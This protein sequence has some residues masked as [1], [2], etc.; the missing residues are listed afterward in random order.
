[1]H[2]LKK[3]KGPGR[4]EPPDWLASRKPERAEIPI[5][6]TSTVTIAGGQP[7]GARRSSEAIGAFWNEPSFQDLG[8]TG[9]DRYKVPEVVGKPNIGLDRTSSSQIGRFYNTE[10]A[11]LY[12]PRELQS[13][14]HN[15]DSVRS[16]LASSASCARQSQHRAEM[17]D[18]RCSFALGPRAPPP[19]TLRCAQ[20]HDCFLPDAPLRREHS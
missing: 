11:E 12:G 9:K 16:P 3:P 4:N 5:Q 8:F 2:G 19:G 15:R 18:E 13:T 14:A 17:R 20:P 6:G 1:M 7:K 10:Y